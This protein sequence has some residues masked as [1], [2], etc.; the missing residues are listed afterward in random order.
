MAKNDDDIYTPRILKRPKG[1]F[2]L[3]GPRGTGKSTW[4]RREFPSAAVVDLLS[5]ETY[6]R[7][8]AHP[9]HFAGQMRGLERGSWVVIDEIQ[10]L[11]NLLNEVHRF[12]E[13][14]SLRFILCGSSAR[15]LR[16]GGVNLLG[17]RAVERFMHPFLPAELGD[18]FSLENALRFGLLPVV[19]ASEDRE[20]SLAAYARL[21]LREEIQA[22]ALV[23]NLPGFARFLPVAA[24]A[25]ARTVNTANIARECGVARTT[26]VGYI[27]I[28]E[29]TLM[30]FRLP[31][32]EAKLR[33]RERK[34][35]KLY[36][37]DPG[38][39]RA[40]SGARGEVHPQER[41]ELFEGLVAQVIRASRDAFQACDGFHYWAP[42]EAART[43]V[44][45][46]LTRS[47]G[48]VAVE[49]KSGARFDE[50]WCRGLRAISGL[51]GLR[52]RM[53]VSPQG[54]RQK[55]R[56]GIE[57][58]PFHEFARMLAEDGLWP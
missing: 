3:L 46:L 41:G 42:A 11:P 47:R 10:R 44:D 31:A 34:L 19:M 13:E 56:D 55:T 53:I 37:F 23:R 24:L 8:L 28:L 50:S 20:E 45:F 48:R 17:G 58:V 35:P 18:R 14:R 54:P 39:V 36:W 57:V 43:E 15:K 25:H 51:A 33:V 29:A 12:I 4:I 27:E 26:V 40:V 22:E 1:S 16:R 2:F 32:F 6:Q 21:Y 52:R 5:E 38:V 7:L 30:C 49:A 9:G